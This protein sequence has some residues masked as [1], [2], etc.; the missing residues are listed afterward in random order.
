MAPPSVIDRLRDALSGQY[1]LLRP[2]GEGGMAEVFVA[3]DLRHERDVAIKV[4]KPWVAQQ[5]GS[6][7]FLREIK[8]IAGLSHPHIMPLHDSG[9]ADGLLF[10]VMP[11]IEGPT[12]GEWLA[13]EGRPP[14][15]EALRLGRALAQALGHAHAHG[16]VHRDV[17]PGNVLLSAGEPLL[18][19]FG[20]AR[21]DR[22][23]DPALT[24]AGD[25]MGTP[26]T[27]SP[28]QAEGGGADARS[29]VYSLGCV[30]FQLITGRPPFDGRSAVE[31]IR[32]HREQTPPDLASQD[33]VPRSVATLVAACL[34]KDP[35][36]RPADGDTV[37]AALDGSL[38]ELTTGAARQEGAQRARRG[39]RVAVVV[40][41]L[42]TV[43]VGWFWREHQQTTWVQEEGLPGIVRLT[44]ERAW[45]EAFALAT[46]VEAADP[47]NPQLV[48]LW[49][50]FSREV[51]LVSDPPGALVSQRPLDAADGA[52]WEPLGRTP[53]T[54]RLTHGFRKLRYELDGHAPASIAGHWYY[55]RGTSVRLVPE[56][57]HVPGMVLVT[58]GAVS[59]N[60]P[61]LDHL[62]QVQLGSA[63]IQRHEVTNAEYAR[64]VAAGGY[65]AP[66]WWV[67][68]FVSE[69]APLSFEQ[70]MA[71]LVDGTGRPGPAGWVAGDF[72]EGRGQHPVVGVSWFE[73]AA[74]C[75]WLGREL[76]TVHHWNRGAETRLAALV[77][78]KSNFDGQGT[79]PVGTRDA[80]SAFDLQDMAGNAREWCANATDAGQ[81][82]ILGGGFDDLPYMFN[83]FFAQD[84][85]NRAASNGFRTSLPLEPSDDVVTSVL[86]PPFRDFLAE[87]QASDAVFEVY[88]SQ[89]DYDPLPL[90]TEVLLSDDGHEGYTTQRIAYD[91]PYGGERGE[92]WVYLPTNRPGPHPTVVYFPGSNAIHSDDSSS[93]VRTRYA[94][95]MRQGYALVAP[96]LKGTYERGT[97]LDSD[98][99]NESQL[100]RDHMVA[101][102]MDIRRAVDLAEALPECDADRLAYFGSSWGGAMGPVMMA[103]EPRFDAGALLVAGLLFQHARP[104]VDAIHYVGRVTQP[105][106][107]LNG[108][109]DHFFPVESSQKPLLELLGTPEEHKR[110]VLE[111]GGHSVEQTTLVTEVLA[112]LER[113]LGPDAGG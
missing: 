45:D 63:W 69:G 7:R 66:Q 68:P 104:E 102:G 75:R 3:R 55:L 25:A 21:S 67:E 43:A 19:D 10:A 76:P 27:M 41:L 50:S 113:W 100:W 47:D 105:V 36:D 13:A 111:E 31:L 92:A 5:L 97:E 78:P 106:L 29:D 83:D 81:R 61:G 93:L 59:L 12:L 89:F 16:V 65:T 35:G 108:A 90:R 51:E 71:R 64:F 14:L 48:T 11:C 23:E 85:W 8:L 44:E 109:Y 91:L 98:Y 94:W 80:V 2:L 54:V 46:E 4:L 28:E 95:L 18:A 1:E 79:E 26:L 73:A 33:G 60:I 53:V 70:A 6:E 52:A 20:L 84:P 62:D 57:E 72:A 88:R 110:Y 56:G 77:V 22:G 39:T 101:W 96:T 107:M 103:I 74:Y 49:D 34:A 32:R 87:E 24:Q 99:P 17:K 9:E 86:E 42:L 112:W 38:R 37:A 82:A 15:E 40:A 58:G 30:L